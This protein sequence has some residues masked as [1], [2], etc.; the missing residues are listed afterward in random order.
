[1]LRAISAV[2]PGA[3]PSP[4][5]SIQHL[6][7]GSTILTAKPITCDG[8]LTYGQVIGVPES[9]S[10]L[11]DQTKPVS[12]NQGS[13][14]KYPSVAAYDTAPQDRHPSETKISIFVSKPRAE[15]PGQFDIGVMERHPYSSQLFI[16]MGVKEEEGFRYLVVVGPAGDAR[17][18]MEHAEAF[19]VHGKQGISYSPG[20]WHAPIVVLGKEDVQFAVV[21]D[22]NGNPQDDT[23]EVEIE[24]KATVVIP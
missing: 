13:A 14:K 6:P 21:V 15:V 1:M 22:T 4:S 20:T 11:Q 16:P 24:G 8:F 7:D 2:Q 19:L 18:R 17:P 12:A 23:E 9:G 3:R 10:M 5:E